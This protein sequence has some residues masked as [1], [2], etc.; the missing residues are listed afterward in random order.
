[1]LVLSAL[2]GRPSLPCIVRHANPAAGVAGVE[3]LADRELS[4][5]VADA[6]IRSHP[7]S[8][9]AIPGA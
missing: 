7:R 6:L 3:F 5:R 4:A 2:D 8:V 9:Q 1:V